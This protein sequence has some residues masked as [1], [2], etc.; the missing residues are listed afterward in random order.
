MQFENEAKIYKTFFVS[1]SLTI[2]LCLSGVFLGMPLRTRSI[3]SDELLSRA[4]TDFNSIL[5]T[6][7]WNAHYGGVYVEKKAGMQSNPYLENPDIKTIDGRTFTK[8][9]PSLMTREISE[10][11]RKQGKYFFHI[12]SLNP[13]NPGNK[14][15]L[16]EADAL[17]A[18]AAGERERYLEESLNGRAY[19]RYI[20]PLFT[21]QD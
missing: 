12:T 2:A 16:F 18:F 21:A 3:M 17:R 20:A 19:F 14:P 7:E 4:R 9:N 5:I 1:M 6:R 10:I 11:S 8:K 13:L 15:D